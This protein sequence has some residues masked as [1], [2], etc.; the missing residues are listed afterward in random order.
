MR[1][2]VCL[3]TVGLFLVSLF[4]LGAAR[5]FEGVTIT[6]FTQPPPFI[7]KPV[8]MF[9]PDWERMTGGKVRLITAPWAEL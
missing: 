6:V 3:V 2:V 8:Q 7:A 9:A 4:A 5:K 1:K